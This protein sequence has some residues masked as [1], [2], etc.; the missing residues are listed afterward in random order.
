MLSKALSQAAGAGEPTDPNWANVSLL[1]HGDGT[2]GA[3]NNTFVDS[4]SGGTSITRTG[5][6][7]QG[8][9]SPYYDAAG[10]YDPAIHGGS[11]YFPSGNHYLQTVDTYA[12]GSQ[13]FTIEFWVYNFADSESVW[14]AIDGGSTSRFYLGY[15]TGAYTFNGAISFSMSTNQWT[16]LA[17]VREGTGTNQFKIYVNGVLNATGTYS[18]TVATDGFNISTGRTVGS[19]Y[20]AHYLSDV[21]VVIGT[22]VYTSNFTPPTAPLTAITNTAF[23]CNFTNAGIFDNAGLNDLETVGN[24]QI[25]TSVKKY[26][27][28]SMAF[29]GTGDYIS[30]IDTPYLQLGTN[31]FTIEFW[32]YLNTNSADRGFVYKG[33]SGT[34]WLVSLRVDNTV[35]FKVQN[36]DVITS[37]GT[38]STGQWYYIAV[39]REGTGT[40]QTKLYIDG[41]NDG[42]ATVADNFTQTDELG[43]GKN[44][45][46]G[47]YLNGYID[48]LRIT[49]GV[50]R[51]TANFTPPT[52]A[53]PNSGPQAITYI[54]SSNSG[55]SNF[56][57]ATDVVTVPLVT[58]GVQVGD[59]YIVS[60]FAGNN[61]VNFQLPSGWTNAYTFT[62][63]GTPDVG[64]TVIYRFVTGSEGSS[65]DVVSSGACT[66]GSSSCVVFRGV[67]SIGQIA[68]GNQTNPTFTPDAP[69][70]SWG[71]FVCTDDSATDVDIPAPSGYMEL[72]DTSYANAVGR[73]HSFCYDPA[74]AS[75]SNGITMTNRA[76][77]RIELKK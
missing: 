76:A 16:H 37:T 18:T 57:V 29:D 7:T 60:V 44:R 2:N 25:S 40:N 27:T 31:N 3:Q 28:G 12:I 42:T 77:V 47:D 64:G 20:A 21:R 4:S 34:G 15:V 48:D 38:L 68:F 8:S 49:R 23:L 75:F 9:F 17:F 58:S 10:N 55:A 51:Y 13:N 54:D 35:A 14:F 33:G 24:A 56:S 5:T 52:R 71:V 72:F 53:F 74:I 36:V 30:T 63:L 73:Q 46:A 41:V 11:G 1:L 39:V 19:S 26:G 70:T 65:V 22:A 66:N 61:A 50:A 69:S 32:V 67:S 43:I 6:P 45:G 62:N 59:L